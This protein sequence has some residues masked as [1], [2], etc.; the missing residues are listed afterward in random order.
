MLAL[1][2]SGA[3]AAILMKLLGCAPKRISAT[4]GLA[5]GWVGAAASSQPLKLQLP[6]VRLVVASGLLYT[7]GAIVYMYVHA[8]EGRSDETSAR[9]SPCSDLPLGTGETVSGDP[10]DPHSCGSRIASCATWLRRTH[11]G[12]SILVDLDYVA[13]GVCSAREAFEACRSPRNDRMGVG[14]GLDHVTL[15]NLLVEER[16]QTIAASP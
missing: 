1:V 8:R 12:D 9:G 14:A 4:I 7:A 3:L 2:W 10:R 5:L 6:G 15:F 11:R 13:S 16:G